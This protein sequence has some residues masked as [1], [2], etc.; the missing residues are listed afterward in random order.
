[1]RVKLYVIDKEKIGNRKDRC[2]TLASFFPPLVTSWR[3]LGVDLQ[4]FV[5]T[6][7]D[8]LGYRR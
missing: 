7:H 1:M 2:A 4:S 6:V 8:A 3:G 5:M